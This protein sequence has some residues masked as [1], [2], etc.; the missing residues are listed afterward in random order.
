MLLSKMQPLYE[1]IFNDILDIMVFRLVWQFTGGRFHYFLLRM[2]G[3]RMFVHDY[4]TFA[5]WRYVKKYVPG[6]F[7]MNI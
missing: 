5:K 7:C 4:E 1:Q 3:R 2:N 6:Q